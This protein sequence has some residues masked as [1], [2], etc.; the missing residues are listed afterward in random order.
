MMPDLP[1]PVTT[2]RPGQASR[3][4]T[5]CSNRWSMRSI[6]PVMASASIRNTLLAESEIIVRRDLATR[7]CRESGWIPARAALGRN[8]DNW[9]DYQQNTLH[10]AC[11]VLVLFVVLVVG[12]CIVLRTSTCWKIGEDEVPE[13]KFK[14]SE[15][16]CRSVRAAGSEPQAP[17]DSSQSCAPGV[18]CL[19]NQK[20]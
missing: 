12:F 5:A 13:N 2:T 15:A 20:S 17:W 11:L 18:P 10:S 4:S 6:K 14:S 9:N 8:D 1:M 16:A 3:T 19:E 7:R